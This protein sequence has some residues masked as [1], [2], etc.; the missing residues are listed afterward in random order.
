MVCHHCWHGFGFMV[1]VVI[2]E[3]MLVNVDFDAWW[4]A[5]SNRAAFMALRRYC[6]CGWAC[7]LYVASWFD[8]A[9][10]DRF[11]MSCRFA[12]LR[13]CLFAFDV[14]GGDGPDRWSYLRILDWFRRL[15]RVAM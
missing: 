2:W 12:A 4:C 15:A 9:G 13:A 8:R 7:L 6:D 3:W 5:M 11:V 10:S 14:S 1:V